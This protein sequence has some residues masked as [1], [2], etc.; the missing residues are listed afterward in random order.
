MSASPASGG[1]LSTHMRQLDGLRA[2]A[3]LLVL[4]HHYM[5]RTHTLGVHWGALGVDLFF[6]LSGFLIT[7]ILLRCR[8]LQEE[9]QSLGFTAR[10][11]YMRRFLRIFPL[12]YAVLIPITLGF[13][14]TP[15]LKLSLW[16][17]TYNF[18]AAVEG[19]GH[20]V[21]HFWTLAVEEQFYLFWPW[22]ILTVPRKH[23]PKVL[24][25]TILLGPLSRLLLLGF[26]APSSALR[27]VLF[28]C[29]DTLALGALLAYVVHTVGME[30]AAR[31][32]LQRWLLILGLPLFVLGLWV[33][34]QRDPHADLAGWEQMVV[35]LRGP[36]CGWVV[37]RAAQGFS[38]WLGHLLTLRPLVYLGQ[39]SYGIYVFHAFALLLSK[40]VA[41]YSPWTRFFLYTGVTIAVASLSWH[42]FEARINAFK[43]R[44]PY[45]APSGDPGPGRGAAPGSGKTLAR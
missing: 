38:G 23:L 12:Y 16:S 24:W 34:N 20:K 30:A 32:K 28:C 45:R 10:Q 4:Y 42:L 11:F 17:Y 26:E 37:L 15:N 29:L 3:V 2:I 21:S 19:F 31:G 22:L 40:S 18:Y 44:F 7:G 25:G 5:P 8:G 1:G 41:S 36:L 33:Q 27:A 9:G 43:D 13:T 35:F 14:L 6:V 39:I